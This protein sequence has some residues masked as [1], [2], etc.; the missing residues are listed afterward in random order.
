MTWRPFYHVSWL[1]WLIFK[2]ISPLILSKTTF[3]KR[4]TNTVSEHQILWKNSDGLIFAATSKCYISMESLL[5][6]VSCHAIKNRKKVQY[7]L[8][9]LQ[10][11]VKKTVFSKSNQV[12][13]K[14]GFKLWVIIAYW[15]RIECLS[16]VYFK[17]YW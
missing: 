14:I 7:P 1:L 4:N 17:L 15:F 2:Y 3:K 8:S 6:I 9:I 16:C 10:I 11:R 12:N 5:S 13:L